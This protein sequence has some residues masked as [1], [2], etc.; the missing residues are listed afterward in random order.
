MR[1]L[2]YNLQHGVFFVRQYDSKYRL[3]LRAGKTL[4]TINQLHIRFLIRLR[5]MAISGRVKEA[6]LNIMKYPPMTPKY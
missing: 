6:R 4:T 5:D 3:L 1:N 2:C